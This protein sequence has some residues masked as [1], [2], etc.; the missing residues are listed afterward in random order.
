MLAFAL[1]QVKTKY[2]SGITQVQ[3]YLP[4]VVVFG[5]WKHWIQIMSR[6]NCLERSNEFAW[7]YL[8]LC[9]RRI[10]FSLGSSLLLVLALVKTRL[11]TTRAFSMFLRW[12]NLETKVSLWKRV[13]SFPYTLR[14][15]N[16][17]RDHHKLFWICVWR[18][19]GQG[20]NVFFESSV[21]KMFCVDTK[22][23]SR[24]FQISPVWRAFFKGSI[25]VTNWC[26]R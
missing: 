15:G 17:K 19:L 24:R 7:V 13:K 18:K 21:F 8:C 25:F 3:E 10:S 6:R 12:G 1:R 11:Q 14:L 22:T 23:Q 20:N 16:W 2:S 26:G 9:L 5:H 4:H